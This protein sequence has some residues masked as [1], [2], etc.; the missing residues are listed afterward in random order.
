MTKEIAGKRVVITGGA[1]F[2]GHHLAL[3]LTKQG[4]K[5]DVIDSLSVN[6]LNVFLSTSDVIQNRSLYLHLIQERLHLLEQSGIQVHVM[7]AR[8]YHTLSP[9]LNSLE[10]DVLIHLAAVAHANVANKD[11]YSTFDH[12]L[13]TLENSLDSVRS[14]G[15]HFIYFSSSMVYGN[16]A[17][18][19]VEETTV[20]DP[21]GVYGALKFSGE[22]MVIAY[23]QA[24]DMPYTIIRPSALYGER[25]VSR[26]VGQV[27]IES[28]IQGIDVTVTGDG[29]DRLDFTYVED[30]AQ[31]ISKCIG[32][33]ASRGEIFNLTFGDSRSINQMVEI[34]RRYFPDVNV[35]TVKKDKLTPDRGTLSVDKARK[36]IGYEPQFPLEVGFPRYIEW[37]RNL[38]ARNDTLIR[39]VG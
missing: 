31:G 11:P 6:N 32:T 5:V 33:D 9:L 18:G 36:L 3:A 7:D 14:R 22:K 4:A 12:S 16:F 26:R 10:P 13:R 24:F 34:L 25:C 38:F 17:T 19:E 20:C 8:D 1:G 15:T 29:E 27:F 30:V 23:G 28:A 35:T 39:R 37:Y 21:L 2:I